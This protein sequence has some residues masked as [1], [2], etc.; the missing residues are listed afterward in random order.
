M[1]YTD[2]HKGYIGLKHKDYRHESVNHGVHEYIKGKAHTN[3]VE[4]FWSML[5]RSYVGVYHKIAVGRH[6]ARQESTMDNMSK[7]AK[8]M[9]D[10]RLTYEELTA[11][12]PHERQFV[13]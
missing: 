7:V 9:L 4:S 3:G 11:E 5:K 10:R 8:G 13:I 6:N 1:V 2:Q 12:V